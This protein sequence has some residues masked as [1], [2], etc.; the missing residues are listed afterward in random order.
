MYFGLYRENNSYN[1]FVIVCQMLFII[2]VVLFLK[3]KLVTNDRN[4][5]YREIL[6]LNYYSINYL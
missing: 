4:I 6:F 2:F 1:S 5:F 3:K